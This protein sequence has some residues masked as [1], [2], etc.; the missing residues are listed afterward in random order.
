ML[1][2][3][4][5]TLSGRTGGAS[6]WHSDG[7]GSDHRNASRRAVIP[8]VGLFDRRALMVM[9][10]RLA[11]TSLVAAS[12][13]ICSP[14]CTVQCGAVQTGGIALCRVLRATSKLDFESLTPL[15]VT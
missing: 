9:G 4:R 15:H 3:C 11:A 2:L 14:H 12:L 1:Q 5:H 13:V 10:S 6:G 7:H 8:T